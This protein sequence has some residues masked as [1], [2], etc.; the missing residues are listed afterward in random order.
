MRID[1]FH[2][3]DPMVAI[4]GFGDEHPPMNLGLA[5]QTFLELIRAV[6]RITPLGVFAPWGVQTGSVSWQTLP[7]PEYNVV[8]YPVSNAL[9]QQAE[10]EA[11]GAEI[12]VVGVLA[13][14]PVAKDI[15][16]EAFIG[17][18]FELLQSEAVYRLDD[19]Q[20]SPRLYYLFTAKRRDDFTDQNG[21]KGNL[22]AVA[23]RLGGQLVYPLQTPRTGQ[24]RPAPSAPVDTA[25]AAQQMPVAPAPAPAPRGT[26]PTVARAPRS[27]GLS[28]W[29][30]VGVG[31]AAAWAGWYWWSRRR[32][33]SG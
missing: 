3:Y 26:V 32:R 22:D 15:A 13:P 18:P 31:A 9:V 25:I 24:E 23:A 6:H 5:E 19:P 16:D 8:V 21:G 4:E 30:Y 17:T 10:K 27:A 2:H 12:A 11:F 20:P 1:T 14:K 28:G 29:V 33:R 7:A